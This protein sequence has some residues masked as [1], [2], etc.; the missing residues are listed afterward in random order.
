[1]PLWQ[2]SQ[3]TLGHS[4]AGQPQGGYQPQ[5]GV[6]LQSGNS[7]VGLNE[8]LDVLLDVLLLD[9]LL[10]DDVLLL[11]RLLVELEERDDVLLLLD[12]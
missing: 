2:L 9:E 6:V 11:L 12:S 10:L 7:S 5:R 8:E 4:S 3:L 1:M